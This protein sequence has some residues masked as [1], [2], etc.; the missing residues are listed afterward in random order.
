M[1]AIPKIAVS[2]FVDMKFMS[3]PFA[4]LGVARD[5]TDD[6]IKA[7][8]R[9]LA[10]Q[11]H[12]DRNPGDKAAEERF[13]EI[14]A[15]YE[16]L[17]DPIKRQ[18]AQGQQSQRGPQFRQRGPDHF[19]F[20]FNSGGFD[21]NDVFGTFHAARQHRNN[22]LQTSY[23]VTLEQAFHGAEIELELRTRVGTRY[24]RFTIPPG[25]DNGTRLRI[26]GEGE[27]VY[28][29]LPAG[30]LYV[31]IE[32]AQHQRFQ[33][34]SQNLTLNLPIDAFDAIL[35]TE[36]TVETIEGKTITVT[37]P[38]GVQQGQR[39]RVSGHGMPILTS[40]DLRGDLLVVLHLTTPQ[41]LTPEQ[42][43]L[44]GRIKAL[45]RTES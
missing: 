1:T 28:G 44:V 45:G 2:T 17:K 43:A 23:A 20:S 39:L 22:D 33:R 7:A 9:K 27:R 15:A 34:V 11:Y 24:A 13:K 40:P 26:Q 37:V 4:I 36:M 25:V 41:G 38:E 8:F 29:N 19:E 3:D 10:M 42:L 31:T 18:F 14:N 35:G 30:D 16:T 21:F 6:Q 32:V 12:P 5:A